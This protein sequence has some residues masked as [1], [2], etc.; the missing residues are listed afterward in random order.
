MESRLERQ[1]LAQD[2]VAAEPLEH[3]ADARKR[4][5]EHR[6]V[7]AVVERH[8][9]VVHAGEE[10]L[11]TLGSASDRP[12]GDLGD[13]Q[14]S[15][16]QRGED[17]LERLPRDR[18]R[19]EQRRPLADRV[20]RHHGGPDPQVVEDLVQETSGED[21]AR[22][23]PLQVSLE[24]GRQGRLS[25]PA[26]DVVDA[27][28]ERALDPREQK[29][30]AAVLGRQPARREHERAG[31]VAERAPRLGDRARVRDPLRRGIEERET[32]GPGSRRR[33]GPRERVGELLRRR[34][35]QPQPGSLGGRS[36]RA[37][38][39]QAH[40]VML[41]ED[42]VGV[43]AAEAEG[44]HAGAPRPLALPGDGLAHQAEAGPLD[45]RIRVFAVQRRGLNPVMNRQRG[46]DEP[47]HPRGRHRVTDHRLDRAEPGRRR[48]VR[49][50]EDPS[51]RLQ[52]GR[53]PVRGGRAVRLDHPDRPALARIDPGLR[54]GALEREHLAVRARVEHARR[55]SVAR[56]AAAADD[57]I[58]PVVVP[59]GVGQPLE[60]HHA[61][62]FAD[63]QAVRIPVERPDALAAR[64]RAELGEHGPEGGVLDEVHAARQH[65]VAA[66]RGE[67][68]ARLVDRQE[69]A[70]ARGVDDVR[71]TVQ[72][73]PVRDPG[74]DEVRDRA[75]DR[76]GPQP[77]DLTLIAALDLRLLLVGQGRKQRARRADQLLGRPDGLDKAHLHR[78]DV[79]AAAQDD[80]RAIAGQLAVPVACVRQRSVG[81]LQRDQLIRLAAAHG[82]RHH[83]PAQ[84][85][86]FGQAVDEPAATTIQPV[87]R[88]L[89]GLEEQ[90]F[91]PF[92]GSVGDRVVP[93]PQ[94]LPERI[95]VPRA[96]EDARHS[97][98]RD[99]GGLVRTHGERGIARAGRR[100]ADC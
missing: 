32:A 12:V 36:P 80:P 27:R 70:R 35:G 48:A 94:V 61:G 62:A 79:P 26:R 23:P 74:R 51:Q 86:E 24:H 83:A 19:R 78:A 40:A 4:A 37:R 28:V 5:A 96:R 100:R 38:P 2:P 29:R 22:A 39:R 13:R 57:G 17:V 92:G 1:Q 87:E 15:R 95:Q 53:V 25:E 97:D 98:D 60:H 52:L 76:V 82:D 18:I 63:Q 84:R 44:V 66:P 59:L 75:D 14:R 71:G 20:S 68:D 16:P 99:V 69:R 85:I 7:R 10:R 73:E 72:V 49:R 45:G 54:P 56:Y 88:R 8:V 77:L 3:G 43:D 31:P 65:E 89:V 81:R 47:G 90:R 11:Q 67:L 46:L 34:G 58:D 21:D 91:D 64:E 33:I 6:L 41:L 30:H 50:S 55:A 9:H 93:R 42:D